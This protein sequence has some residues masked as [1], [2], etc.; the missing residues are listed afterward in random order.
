MTEAVL[1]F[2]VAAGLANVAGGLLV[3]GRRG[4]PASLD[5]LLAFG[6]GFLLAV[7]LLEMIPEAL[8]AAPDNV[9]YVLGG[10]VTLYL[11]E[12]FFLN[13]HLHHHGEG[14]DPCCPLPAARPGLALATLTG[15][16]LHTF[17]DG[18]S[19]SAGFA[20]DLATAVAVFAAVLLHKVPDGLVIAS[21]TLAAGGGRHLALLAAAWLGVATVVGAVL[22]SS[23]LSGASGMDRAVAPALLAFSAGI[24]IY[25]AASDLIPEVNRSRDRRLP[26]FL[27]LGILVALLLLRVVLSGG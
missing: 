3:V 19:V 21:V 22:T 5:R 23:Y 1:P 12:R 15:M 11:T 13:R 17:F 16:S 10:F 18:V 6:A 25:V 24:F 27:L 20:A 26:L 2:A 7:A 8:E 14:R 9:A 4:M